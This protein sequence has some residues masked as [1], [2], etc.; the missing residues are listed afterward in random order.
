LR[1]RNLP[2]KAASHT[3]L[4][5]IHPFSITQYWLLIIILMPCLLVLFSLDVL[6]TLW[7]RLLCGGV[8]DRVKFGVNPQS[9]S[10]ELCLYITNTSPCNTLPVYRLPYLHMQ[11]LIQTP[12]Q[13]VPSSFSI[14]LY[15]ALDWYPCALGLVPPSFLGTTLPRACTMWLYYTISTPAF[16]A[17]PLL[18]LMTIVNAHKNNFWHM[19]W[20]H[21]ISSGI[22]QACI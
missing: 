19:V 20:E 15:L 8:K 3:E 13:I 16:R 7:C 9:F 12:S 2:V 11:M 18:L 21:S 10:H 17:P 4:P 6:D 1:P 14:L 5:E 22:K